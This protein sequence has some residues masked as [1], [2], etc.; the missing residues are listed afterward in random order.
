M[1]A[2]IYGGEAQSTPPPGKQYVGAELVLRRFDPAVELSD[3][4]AVN[5]ATRAAY[6]NPQYACVA[7]DGAWLDCR[8]ASGEV[9]VR[10]VWTVSDAAES[11]RFTLYG[12]K[13]AGRVTIDPEGPQL[14]RRVR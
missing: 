12:R 14:P 7:P 3:V 1:A 9:S 11:L 5:P 8:Q 10:L 2:W 13:L 6:G 4:E